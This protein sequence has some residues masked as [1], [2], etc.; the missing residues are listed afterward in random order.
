VD[1]P[2]NH[3]SSATTGD[4][5]TGHR[6][7]TG[8]ITVMDL[9]RRQQG[10]VRIPSAD[11]QD[12]VQFM[13]D[14][15][16][17]ALTVQTERRSWLSRGAKLAG[18]ALGS[19]ALCGAVYAASALT[20][21]RQPSTPGPGSS[22]LTGLGALRPDAVAAQLSGR[23]DPA[24]AVPAQRGSATGPATGSAP[25]GH[26]ATGRVTGT[27]VGAPG[28]AAERTAAGTAADPTGTDGP[29]SA[30]DVVRAFYQLAATDPSVAME[31]LAPSLLSADENGFDQAWQSMTR[32]QVESVKQTSANTVEAVV[33]MLSPDSTWLR[34]VELLHVTSGDTPL[35]NG[36]E[37]L[38]AQRG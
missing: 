20:E 23:A 15:L 17:T 24:P 4:T 6:H 2:N 21:H 14:L 34:V 12:T 19:L 27:I 7:E 28:S 25:T 8:S 1:S 33:R 35:I 29:L 32:I 22:V 30:S 9:I 38:S 3:P 36:A 31:L 26:A 5:T 16:G 18:L 11:E 13:D 10:P 37:L